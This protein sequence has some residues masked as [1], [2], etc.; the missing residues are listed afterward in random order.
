MSSFGCKVAFN[1]GELSVFAKGC[2]ISA[3]LTYVKA[4]R[5]EGPTNVPEARAYRARIVKQLIQHVVRGD[6]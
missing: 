2:C 1:I 3:D 6:S 5:S 4:Q